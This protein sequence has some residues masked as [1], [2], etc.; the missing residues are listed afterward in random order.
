[1]TVHDRRT[2]ALTFAPQSVD[3]KERTVEL[4]ASTGEGVLRADLDGPFIERPVI[5]KDSVDTSRVDGMPV[6]DSHRQD[7]LDRIIGVVRQVRIEAGLLIV[8][9]QI[10]ERHEAYWRDI[11]AGIIRNVSIGYG[12]VRYEDQ[13][14]QATGQRVRL[15]TQWTLM[16]VS[17]VAV[18]ADSGAKIRNLPMP[19]EQTPTTPAPAPPVIQPAPQTV[20]RAAINQ[21]IRA[22][23]QS[24]DI[25]ESMVNDLIDRGASVDEARAAIIDTLQKKS[26]RTTP[27]PAPRVTL[28][29][30]ND[31]PADFVTRAGEALFARAVPSHKLSEPARPLA[32]MTTL[33]LARE[34]LQR[35]QI[36]VIGLSP[37]DTITR[38][39]NTTS[40][41]PAIFGNTANRSMRGAYEAAPAVLKSLARQTTAKDFREKTKIQLG[42]APMLEKVG[43][44]G[45]Y[46]YG[47]M[48][49]ASS[50]YRIDTFG[51]IIG[52]SR[53]AI[54]NDDLG[55][56]ADLNAKFGQAAAEFEAQFL[57]SLLESGSGN[58]PT[59]S[60]GNP[61]F[62]TASHGN[63]AASGA[64]PGE[65]TLSAGR[66]AM[67]K[68]K[69]I[70]GRAINVAPRYVL[71]PADIE[72]ATE[73]L[74]AT[75]QPTKSSDV[76]PF[77]GKFELLVEARL[78]S[79]TRWY[80]AGDPALIE[81][82]EYSYLQGEEG[83]Q[84]VTRVGF[85]VDGVET[86]CR[87]DFGAA[88]V[89]WRSWYMNAGA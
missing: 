2:R 28:I 40:D 17:L 50:S 53:Q 79:A 52:L 59:M 38:A 78:S 63:K 80:L 55:A 35:S 15:I 36:S 82:L 27:A 67:R 58:G 39:L 83:P 68:Q 88:F 41:F 3:D 73:K 46:K 81:G 69:G 44:A 37:A 20:T 11:K 26:Q 32:S 8:K 47:T 64:A 56:F 19:L 71:V 23:G 76:N 65:N 13:V 29:S 14:D 86:K 34:C 33:D 16:E 4:V 60:D 54:V 7:G 87:L 75:I 6:L 12:V 74:L 85:D 89:D 70:D 10:S 1:M 22:L 49:E 57:V 18:P 48:P 77:G 61:L 24:F 31:N 72:T 30:S 84:I 51:K 9:V 43:E 21:E 66:L 62:H 45:E 5:S 25:E 42:G